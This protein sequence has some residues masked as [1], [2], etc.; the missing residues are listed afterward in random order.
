MFALRRGRDRRPGLPETVEFHDPDI[1]VRLRPNSRA[2]RF[3][4]RMVEH[5][6]AVLTLPFG[7]EPSD[8]LAFLERNR[9]WL[10]RAQARCP[11]HIAVAHGVAVPVDGVPRRVEEGRGA[12]IALTGDQ[13]SLPAGA[14]PGPAVAAWLKRRARARL[15]PMAE[16]FADTLGRD[17]SGISLRDTR[18]RWGSCTSSG[19]LNFSW[20]LAMAP[21]AVQRYLAAHE[22]AHLAEMNH[23][24]RFWAVLERLLPDYAEPQAWLKREGRALH[25][26]RFD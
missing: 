24:P 12:R 23:S 19:R 1:T 20:R 16:E 7:V 25:R 14:S 9:G 5:G 15:T 4:L 10:A 3:T 13:L 21:E 26:Y 17:L 8:A 11:A 18:S 22:A 6:Q 2:R